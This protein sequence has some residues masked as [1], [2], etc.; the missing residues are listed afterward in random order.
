MKTGFTGTFV[1]PWT[2]TE[3]DGVAAASLDMLRIG[4]V[5]RWSGAPVRLDGPERVLRLEGAEGVAQLRMRATR[6]ARRLA[7]RAAVNK[8][9]P[10]ELGLDTA[11]PSFTLT[12]G[13]DIYAMALVSVPD[14]GALLVLAE[15]ALP[16][17]DHDLWVSHAAI[18]RRQIAP[19]P[20]GGVICFTPG[21]AIL[22]P[23]GPRLIEDLR[24]GDLVFTR[25]NAAQAVLWIGQRHISAAR[26]HVM[27]HL[28]PIRLRSGAMGRGRPEPDLL[29][30]PH[31]R[32]L[33][34]GRAAEALFNTPEVLV[35]AED[36]VNDHSILRDRSLKGVTYIHVLLESHNVIWANGLETESFH[37]AQAAADALDPVQL[38]GLRQ[39]LHSNPAAQGEF[40]RRSL[41]TFE[42]AVL[43]HDLSAM[44]C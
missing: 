7:G 12:D 15:G 31:H 22:T 11:F 27:P 9:V 1:I 26:L 30:S 32:M 36:L 21:T 14:T 29:V 18:D 8:T 2:Q 4:A 5:W 44:G 35:K 23:Q 40:A 37:P 25:D 20:E 33:V 10:A 16:P 41:T 24:Q 13:R 28:R 6:M 3:T 39:T 43:R 34:K 19:R 38:D 42:A 17:P